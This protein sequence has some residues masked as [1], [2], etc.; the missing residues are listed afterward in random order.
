MVFES[1]DFEY[2]PNKTIEPVSGIQNYKRTITKEI[3][4]SLIH[5][6]E[7][8]LSTSAPSQNY[9][10]KIIK[11]LEGKIISWISNGK[12]NNLTEFAG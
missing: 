5:I 4:D 7:E 9:L 11:N 6:T 12:K 8:Y 1:G 10:Y 2:L 3:K